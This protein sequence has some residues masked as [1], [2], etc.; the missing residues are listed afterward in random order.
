MSAF[1][2]L[3]HPVYKIARNIRDL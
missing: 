3:G 2:L 1:A